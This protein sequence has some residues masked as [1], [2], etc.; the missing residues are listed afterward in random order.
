METTKVTLREKGMTKGRKSLYLDIYPAIILPNGKT[1]RRK[2]LGLY[3]FDKPSTVNEKMHNKQTS[4]L[5]ETIQA[6]MQ[7]DIQNS[8][9]G[10]VRDIYKD[11][12]FI[13]YYK[14]T[15]EKR[16]SSKGNYDNWKCSLNYLIKFAGTEVKIHRINQR[17]IEE[18]KNYLITKTTLSTNSKVSYFNKLRATIKE[19]FY[20]GILEDDYCKRV[21]P[22]KEEETEREFLLEDEIQ[23]LIYTECEDNEFKKA[24]LFASF[25]GL[26]FSDIKKLQWEDLQKDDTLGHF[27]RF[28]QK[29]TGGY[30][31]LPIPE[32]A[33]KIIEDEVN[34]EG[35]VFKNLKY[36]SWNDAKLQ[37]WIKKANI[38][39]KITFHCA[40]HTFITL[41]LTL[42]TEIY[43]TSKMAGHKNVKTTQI[44]GNII[45]QKKLEAIN[46]INNLKIKL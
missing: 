8:Q 33:Y 7:I 20:D 3:I 36:Y 34:K 45:D 23:K 38:N 42:G 37:N 32:I 43:T 15:V 35:D 39:K 40:R 6:K 9:H 28:K 25:T 13:E 44:Y 19:A 14:K 41:L 27:I 31:T 4:I 21:K 10:F 17:F 11:V 26:R 46:K 16:Y 12:N 30:E 2:F 1:T 18:F 5:A 22:I 24:F 29:K